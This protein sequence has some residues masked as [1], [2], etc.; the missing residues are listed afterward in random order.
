[1]TM[2]ALLSKCSCKVSTWRIG[3]ESQQY[4]CYH[5]STV[6]LFCIPAQYCYVVTSRVRWGP[7]AVCWSADAKVPVGSQSE[8][9]NSYQPW[10]QQVINHQ[11]LVPRLPCSRIWTTFVFSLY[12]HWTRSLKQRS[13]LKA[14]HTLWVKA[15]HCFLPFDT[16]WPTWPCVLCMQAMQCSMMMFVCVHSFSIFGTASQSKCQQESG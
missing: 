1:M 8:S 4:T 3:G 11:M 16:V 13:T 14:S 12:S 10:Q 6:H 5:V 7:A 15:P 2:T 9:S